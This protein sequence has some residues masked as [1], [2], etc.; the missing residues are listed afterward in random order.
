MVKF[1]QSTSR[2]GFKSALN[3]LHGVILD[4]DQDSVYDRFAHIGSGDLALIELVGP[5][6]VERALAQLNKDPD[7]EYA[8]PN[9]LVHALR[10]PDDTSFHDLWSL[11][12][13]GQTGGTP[14]VDIGATA[15]WDTS[16][17]SRE[18]IVGVIDSG[19]DYRHS[20][21][22]P[23]MWINPDEI[24]DNG[25]DDDNNGYIDDIH[26]INVIDG[27]G[28][29]MDDNGHGTHVSGTI[30]SVG[31]NG[32]G[33]VGVNWHVSIV[34]IKF[35]SSSGR[36]STAHAI[37]SIN[38]ALGLKN[39]GIEIRVLNNSW[40]GGRYSRALEDA[41]RAA[42]DAGILFVAAA[43]NSSSNNDVSPKYPSNYG[44]GNVVAV[45]STDH[46]DDLSHFS[47]YGVTSVDLAAPGSDI[48]STLPGDQ[49]GVMSGTSMAAP[50]VAGAAALALSSNDSLTA[51]QIADLLVTSGDQVAALDG[52]TAGGRRL[53]VARAMEQVGPPIPRFNLR[54]S[55]AWQAVNQEETATYQI[56]IAA[57]GGFSGQVTI[58]VN[59]DPTLDASVD[60][61]PNP[62]PAHSNATLTITTSGTTAPG[63]YSL[64]IT[65]TSGSLVR[66]RS[67]SLVVRRF[68][69]VV[70]SLPSTD[71]PLDIP[72]NNAAGIKSTITV[73]DEID[74][75]EVRVALKIRHSFIGD[76]LVKLVSPSGTEAIL[77][78]HGGGDGHEINKTLY[79]SETFADENAAG[80]WILF[81]SDNASLDGGRILSWSLD[82]TGVL[83]GP[84]FDVRTSPRVWNIRQG[85]E[86]TYD[87]VVAALGGFSGDV[88][89]RLVDN[90]SL[91]ANAAF[92]DA[93]VT[94]PGSA[95]LTIDTSKATRPGNYSLIISGSND[96]KTKSADINLVVGPR[97][98]VAMSYSS[99]N[100]PIDVPG[101]NANGIIDA[102]HVADSLSIDRLSIEVDI[103]HPSISNPTVTLTSPSGTR[104][105]VYRRLGCS[106]GGVHK[107]VH[108]VV[109]RGE[110]SA[111]LWT[112][113]VSDSAP[114]DDGSLQSWALSVTG[115]LLDQSN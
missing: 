20:D 109:F 81:V 76:L 17:G 108:P 112:L 37:A 31:N 80:D 65:G 111:G 91:V 57:L 113:S 84:S 90:P 67:V 7:I 54:V 59:S 115:T 8:E 43:G 29:P 88:E 9:Y 21:L 6:T 103:T 85:Q 95:T 58:S 42:N 1:R 28:D 104:S 4:R 77:H 94:A 27:S 5:V 24:A 102:I 71:T 60:I 11:R 10:S 46:N 40:G 45:A 72:D 62:V 99:A 93:N 25:L 96:G 87:V 66:S 105:F 100:T 70:R 101:G 48:L 56:A 51:E 86:A 39:R 36:G 82:I 110:N 79:L 3:R 2:V 63:E 53:N 47:N 97:E 30:G 35:L 73:D 44:I 61:A 23:N 106:R 12:N 49:Y 75:T 78:D 83:S 34:A 38:Y 114:Y 22:A 64:T 52:R 41:I 89:L 92:S 69:T 18:V 19:V 107:I 50:H 74:I 16:I 55:P 15:A 14:G 68:G 13:T 26:G 33:L 32:T 98:T